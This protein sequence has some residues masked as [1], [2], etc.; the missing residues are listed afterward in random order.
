LAE[1]PQPERHLRIERAPRQLFPGQQPVHQRRLTEPFSW[2]SPE[3]I[4]V[5]PSGALIEK[6]AAPAP[7]SSLSGQYALP[8]RFLLFPA[9]LW[10]HKNHL[11]V[12]KALKQIEP[13]MV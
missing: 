4:E 8:E 10:P 12:L 5:I 2:V 3:Q 6:F 13:C 7:H 11:T 1:A 9:Q